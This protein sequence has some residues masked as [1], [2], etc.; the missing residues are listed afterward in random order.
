MGIKRKA[1]KP[2]TPRISKTARE[3]MKTVAMLRQLREKMALVE[4]LEPDNRMLR[5]YEH[6]RGWAI[7][8]LRRIRAGVELDLRRRDI[9]PRERKSATDHL[10]LISLMESEFADS[11]DRAH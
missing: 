7:I 2:A 1:R 5:E 10:H 4:E 3:T 11:V 8:E 6:M 9:S